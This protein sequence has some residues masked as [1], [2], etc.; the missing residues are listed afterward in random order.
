VDH[1]VN[2]P[3]VQY[4]AKIMDS[5]ITNQDNYLLPP[6]LSSHNPA[7]PPMRPVC[8]NAGAAIGYRFPG[9]IG[10]DLNGAWDAR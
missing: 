8:R 6:S 9:S 1:L 3:T 2:H 7:F 4:L 10:S 5:L